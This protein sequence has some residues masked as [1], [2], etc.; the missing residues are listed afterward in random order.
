MVVVHSSSEGTREDILPEG[1]GMAVD[2]GQSSG[3]AAGVVDPPL[4]IQGH[5]QGAQVWIPALDEEGLAAVEAES[6]EGLEYFTFL[7]SIPP[8][9]HVEWGNFLGEPCDMG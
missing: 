4:G 2:S 5:E 1:A 3:F 8:C 6:K 9:I 7:C